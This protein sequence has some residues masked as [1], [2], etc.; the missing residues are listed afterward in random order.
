MLTRVFAFT[1]DA[2]GR[3]DFRLAFET[4]RG[5]DPSKIEKDDR[6]CL[7]ELQRALEAV[8]VP[9]GELP[10]DVDIDLR[11]RKLQNDGGTIT[12]SQR[13]HEKL[14]HWLTETPFQAGLSVQVEDF[15]DRLSAAEK[16]D[17]DQV[18]GNTQKPRAVKRG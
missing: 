15:E 12:L 11:P 7:A 4:F 6:R 18:D 17:A 10:E 2:K 9:I 8:S 3:T 14:S 13:T 16:V 5:R 1:P